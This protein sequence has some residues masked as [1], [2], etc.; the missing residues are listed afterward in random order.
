MRTTC[1]NQHAHKIQSILTERWSVFVCI[2]I[3]A[4]TA[5]E[6]YIHIF[7]GCDV[8]FRT[9]WSAISCG[10]VAFTCQHVCLRTHLAKVSDHLQIE[11]FFGSIL[12]AH[13]QHAREGKWGGKRLAHPLI[14]AAQL[15]VLNFTHMLPVQK[16]VLHIMMARFSDCTHDILSRWSGVSIRCCK[17]F[18]LKRQSQK[19]F[20]D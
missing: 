1:E 3:R 5:I 6:L 9:V 14:S 19:C 20:N 18:L 10:G 17:W 15:F 8:M 16:V 11:D 4:E 2:S 13:T 12:H 7:S